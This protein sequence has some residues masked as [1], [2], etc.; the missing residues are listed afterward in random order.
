MSAGKRLIILLTFLLLA[1]GLQAQQNTLLRKIKVPAASLSME[2]I[3]RLVYTQAGFHFSFNAGTLGAQR[4]VSFTKKEY[5]L[6]ELLELI[7]TNTG[8]GYTVYKE[9]IIFRKAAVVKGDNAVDKKAAIPDKKPEAP[10]NG[11]T[12]AGKHAPAASAKG[13]PPVI[14][15]YDKTGKHKEKQL[16]IGNSALP[17]ALKKDGA[18]ANKGDYPAITA[19]PGSASNAKAAPDKG[20]PA[21]QGNS[22]LQVSGGSAKNAPLSNNKTVAGDGSKRGTS[23]HNQTAPGKGAAPAQDKSTG[24]SHAPFSGGTAGLQLQSLPVTGRSEPFP[25]PARLA[26]GIARFIAPRNASETDNSDSRWLLQAGLQADDVVDLQLTVMG[27]WQYVYLVA[28]WGTNF[29]TSGFRFGLGGALPLRNEWRLNAQA[30]TG[31]FTSPGI[32]IDSIRTFEARSSLHRLSLQ[33]EKRLNRRWTVAGGPVFNYL[34]TTYYA[35]GKPANFADHGTAAARLSDKT[36]YTL[37]PLYTITDS[38][39]R[40]RSSNV[41]TWLGLQV[42]FFYRINF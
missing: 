11:K 24:D 36:L 5:A 21:A 2:D 3:T 39:D 30:T 27:G 42:S 34:A 16:V 13:V 8:A 37:K 29:R 4:P 32:A 6:G 22:A 28:G 20:E 40:A 17:G 14:S 41:K 31:K 1:A 12:A 35:D 33:L 10:F 23:L 26:E 15:S 9:H 19:N 38:Y 7:K 25:Q 18:A